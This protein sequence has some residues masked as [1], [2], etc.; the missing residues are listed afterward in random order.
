MGIHPFEGVV[1]AE[2]T[3]NRL[4]AFDDFDSAYVSFSVEK[5]YSSFYVWSEGFIIVKTKSEKTVQRT[6]FSDLFEYIISPLI[7]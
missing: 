4:T 1:E 7:N 5:I 2:N 6:I 3:E